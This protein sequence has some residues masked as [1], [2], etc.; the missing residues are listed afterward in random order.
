LSEILDKDGKIISGIDGSF[1]A[2]GYNFN[3]EKKGEPHF[4]TTS[5]ANW[6]ALG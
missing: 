1:S 6:T 4:I 3:F 5:G 2:E